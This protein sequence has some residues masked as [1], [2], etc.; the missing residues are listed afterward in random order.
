MSASII[1]PLPRVLSSVSLFRS[2]S[3][4]L[5]FLSFPFP[6]LSRSLSL[7]LLYSLI[8]P[9]ASRASSRFSA[10]GGWLRFSLSYNTSFSLSLF[11]ANS[12]YFYLFLSLSFFRLFSFSHSFAPLAPLS[13]SF[14]LSFS[15][16]RALSPSFFL[17]FTLDPPS[18]TR[19]T[20]FLP[21]VPTGHAARLFS[22]HLLCKRT[23]SRP[24]TPALHP[25][26][27][28]SST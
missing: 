21:V 18:C 16:V 7:S 20:R 28:P 11:L 12:L 27:S 15:F 14:S 5:S 3:F 6:L 13:L 24:A 25:L 10:T 4:L 19:R 8:Y 2:P 1:P 23:Q 9:L 22:S 17:W 26:S